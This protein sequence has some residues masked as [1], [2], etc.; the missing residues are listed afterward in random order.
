MS[1]V[2]ATTWDYILLAVGF[3]FV[4][5]FHELGHFLAAKW[6][7]VK[8]EQFA[9][10]FGPAIF[11]WRK[12]LGIR[13]GSTGKE[14]EEIVRAE[15]D[16][17][18]QPD[19]RPISETEYRLNWIPLGG[20]VK[21]LG[22]DD[23]K[24]GATADDPRAYNNKPISSRMVIV[25]AGV[26]MNVILAAI[27]FM[28]VFLIGFKA[29][30]AIVGGVQTDSPA[31]YATNNSG[32]RDPLQV[33]DEILTLDGKPQYD[34]TK[35][36]LNTAL[37]GEGQAAS[38]KVRHVDGS[39]EMLH[40]TPERVEGDPKGFLALGI[41]PAMELRGLDPTGKVDED[42]KKKNQFPQDAFAVLPGDTITAIDGQPVKVDEYWKLDRA[43]HESLGHPVTLT[44][45]DAKGEVATRQ[46]YPH[47]QKPFGKDE[48][49]IGGF[50]P[51]TEVHLIM[52]DSPALGKLMP[53]DVILAISQG[54][55]QKSNPSAQDLMDALNKA[56]QHDLKVDMKVLRDGKVVEVKDLTPNLSVAADRKGLGIGLGYDEQNTVVAD[57]AKDSP[58]E[59]AKV[60][61]GAQITAI[62][63]QPVSNWFE[64]AH[65]IAT[66]KAGEPLTIDA[67]VNDN[68]AHYTMTV[69]NKQIE[70]AK[71]MPLAHDLQLHE[72]IRPRQTNNPI[73]AAG[74]GVVETRDFILQFYLTL[75]R[76]VDGT[77]SYKNA[78]GPVGIF[79][80]GAKFADKGAD[81]LIWFL[82][83]ISA[84][85]AVVN[86][87]PIP[88]VDGGL[89]TFLIVEKIRG[90]PLSQEAQQIVQYVGLALL[91]GVFLLV[92]YQDIARM[93]G[94]A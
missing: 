85:L 10:G 58:A 32:A 23:M 77:V 16:A 37:L 78:M 88:I 62:N 48:L 63:G 8:V 3:G 40:F 76:M 54:T 24:P 30:P 12:G 25:S 31:S 6:C 81:W 60:P 28:I 69:N 89:F 43:L 66:A 44:V 93:F 20:Y 80:A 5:F 18:P 91:L 11:S 53:G 67:N 51:R 72:L 65:A 68:V 84:N 4:I 87:L 9:V 34:F 50:V 38:I 92:T 26:I 1:S 55:D 2:L 22:Q 82:A 33:G 94:H 46:I 71:V 19:A 64:V 86:F 79:V 21:M 39:E 45:K 47:F 75:R 35:I 57:V 7:D 74:W 29:P 73:V 59:A 27:G 90:R 15:K 49:N 14:Y 36:A 52:D 61:A 13:A 56:G 70:E 41:V 17:A 83:M 42:L